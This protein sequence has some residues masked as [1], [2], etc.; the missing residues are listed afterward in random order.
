MV[1][2]ASTQILQLEPLSSMEHVSY[3]RGRRIITMEHSGLSSHIISI[4]SL[5]YNIYTYYTYTYTEHVYTI[6][7]QYLHSI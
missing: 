6:V 1:V 5:Q 7:S 2:T 4:I 3:P